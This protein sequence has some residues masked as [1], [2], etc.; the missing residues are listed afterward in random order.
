MKQITEIKEN[1]RAVRFMPVVQEAAIILAAALIFAL[2]FNFL[3]PSGISLFG[4][5]PAKIASVKPT[6]IPQITLGE[7][8]DLFLKNKIVFVD[9]RD[10]F[11]FEE[12]HIA[13]AVNIYPDETALHA[14]GLKNKLSPETII[15]TYCDGPQCPLSK[16]TAQGLQLQGLTGV[17]VLINGWILW[18]DAGYP[19]ARGKK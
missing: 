12:G 3:R 11:S 8:H 6:N 19:V 18:Q 13:G 10:P 7:A 5:S 1:D 16:E 2:V 14:A 17:K 4:F 15:V 9:A